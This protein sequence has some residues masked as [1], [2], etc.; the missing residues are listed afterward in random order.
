MP[1]GPSL[2]SPVS[3][4]YVPC[5]EHLR[6]WNFSSRF[7]PDPPFPTRFNIPIQYSNASIDS[8]INTHWGRDAS[9]D[10]MGCRGF[11]FVRRF[12]SIHP[13]SLFSDILKRMTVDPVI[14]V[15]QLRQD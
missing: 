10:G 7:V 15:W 11:F 14:Q 4:E 5:S 1:A 9:G 2:R 13:E 6:G 12:V 3:G 8:N